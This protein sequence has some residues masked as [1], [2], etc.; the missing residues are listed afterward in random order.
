MDVTC[1]STSEKFTHGNG[2]ISAEG[3]TIQFVIGDS[4]GTIF[5]VDTFDVERGLD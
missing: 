2:I 4:W 1:E 5:K 3:F